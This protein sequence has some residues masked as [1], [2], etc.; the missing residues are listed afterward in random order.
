MG[1]A[2]EAN[3]WALFFGNTKLLPLRADY[4]YNHGMPIGLPDRSSSGST[5]LDAFSW[6]A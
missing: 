5:P 6:L 1:F 3:A 2:A 4:A